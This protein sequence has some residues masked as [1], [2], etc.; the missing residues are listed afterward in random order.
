MPPDIRRL[1]RVA[2]VLGP[3]LSWRLPPRS[4]PTTK[5]D[6]ITEDTRAMSPA[7]LSRYPATGALNTA[8]I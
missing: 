3:N 2:T 4:I 7:D 5:A 1:P 8:H 6:S